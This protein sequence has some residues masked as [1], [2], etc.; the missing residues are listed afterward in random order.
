M[1][2]T[3]VPVNTW[4]EQRQ[5]HWWH[6]MYPAHWPQRGSGCVGEGKWCSSLLCKSHSFSF[7]IRQLAVWD[8]S[9]TQSS[10][11]SFHVLLQAA[12]SNILCTSNNFILQ[13]SLR[14]WLES[15]SNWNTND[16]IEPGMFEEHVKC[17]REIWSKG[18]YTPLKHFALGFFLSLSIQH[19][20]PFC[21]FI[22]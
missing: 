12:K 13:E 17:I 9:N 22:K 11:L 4:F 8:V 18:F 7:E 21:I 15:S 3:T 6:S 16:F 20:L 5:F 19:T 1:L 10:P 14:H 2:Q